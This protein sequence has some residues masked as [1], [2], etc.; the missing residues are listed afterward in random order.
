MGTLRWSGVLAAAL[1]AGCA[2]YGAS[3]EVLYGAVVYTQPRPSQSFAALNKY[4]LNPAYVI[5]GDDPNHVTTTALPADVI[6]AFDANMSS[7]G[8]T[9]VAMPDPLPT[10]P[11]ANTV[12][13]QATVFKGSAGVYYPGYW[14]DYWYYYGCYYGWTYAGSY[15][16]GTVVFEMVDGTGT[17]NVDGRLPVAWAAAIYGIA[18]TSS[19]DIPRLVSGLYRAFDQSPYLAH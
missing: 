14:C 19:Y 4:M 5:A 15:P 7:R 16:Y 3:D 6:A 1:L 11:I 8:W 17:P 18:T 10:P 13:V 12:F 2:G 9:K